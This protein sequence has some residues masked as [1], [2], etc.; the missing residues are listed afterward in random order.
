M[1][2][3]TKRLR[4]VPCTVEEIRAEI[5]QMDARARAQLSQD[6]LARVRVATTV[7]P[8]VLGFFLVHNVTGAVIGR[9]GFKGPPD[10]DGMVEVAYGIEPE[11]QNNG[12][13]TEAAAALVQYAFASPDVRVVRAHTLE[14]ANASAR[15]LA[16]CEFRSVGQVVDPEDGLVWRWEIKDGEVK[17]R[18]LE[19]CNRGHKYRG[20]GPCPVCWPR[21]AKKK[22]R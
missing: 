11:H 18:R 9:C 3:H 4:L 15:V 10:T 1:S 19:T 12:Y 6:W 21:T 17:S 20:E 2:L 5:E 7:D 8:W 13:A 14:Q 16:K 22:K